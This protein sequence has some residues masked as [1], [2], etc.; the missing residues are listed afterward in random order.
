MR[1]RLFDFL[2]AYP[3]QRALQA[4]G[5]SYELYDS[6]RDVWVAWQAD[7]GDAALLPLAAVAA[8]PLRLSRWGIAS[9]GSVL[10]VLLLSDTPPEQWQAILVDQRSMSSVG[11]LRHLMNRD[12]FPSLPFCTGTERERS[13]VRLIIGDAALRDSSA[14]QYQIDLGALA[15]TALRKGT[16]YAVW[17]MRNHIRARL[18][19]VWHDHLPGASL[20]IPDAAGR[21]GFPPETIRRYW[22]HLRYRLPPLGRHYWRGIFTREAHRSSLSEPLRGR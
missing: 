20:W 15:C 13:T 22:R 17:W 14:Y 10:S 18:A 1:I 4:A 9:R 3:Y 8:A 12:L 21:Y 6:P 19:R 16:V 7:P 2:N 5:I 11:I